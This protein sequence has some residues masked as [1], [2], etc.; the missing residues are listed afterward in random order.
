MPRRGCGGSGAW[1]RR[2]RLGARVMA[3]KA[4]R[5]LEGAGLD[6]E[7]LKDRLGSSDYRAAGPIRPVLVKVINEDLTDVA[8]GVTCPTLLLCGRQDTE[9]PVE[10]SERFQRLIPGA[11][12][13]V[14]DGFDHYTVLTTGRHQVAFRIS[15]FV[16]GLGPG[17]R[18][19]NAV[20]GLALVVCAGV[21]LHRRGLV[22][23]HIFQQEEYDSPRFLR[24]WGGHGRSI[25]G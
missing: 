1:A 17:S 10:I 15:R 4:L 2:A 14:L 5:R 9:T 13:A 12:L 11:A 24:G 6:V 21:F 3:Y 23:L 22:Y 16:E 25:N 19:V 20:V 8:M 18:C 7:R